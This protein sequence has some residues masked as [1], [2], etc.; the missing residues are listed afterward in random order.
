MT[1]KTTIVTEQ[2]QIAILRPY[3]S[4]T[5]PEQKD[6]SANPGKTNFGFQMWQCSIKPLNNLDRRLL[7][8]LLF[9]CQTKPINSKNFENV[10]RIGKAY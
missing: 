6:P 7:A 2:T 1:P 5:K 9:F 3:L 8:S 10:F 4:E